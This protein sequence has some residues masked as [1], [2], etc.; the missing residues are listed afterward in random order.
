MGQIPSSHFVRSISFSE[1]GKQLA[2]LQVDGMLRLYKIIENNPVPQLVQ[3]LPGI[4]GDLNGKFQ[5]SWK[6]DDCL[7]V[8]YG[9]KSLR[10]YQ[11]SSGKW[12]IKS[13]FTPVSDILSLELISK[14]LSLI[15]CANDTISLFS[16][17]RNKILTSTQLS[18]LDKSS[19]SAANESFAC[20]FEP[21]RSDLFGIKIKFD[22]K[23]LIVPVDLKEKRKSKLS[24]LTAK[25]IKSK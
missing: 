3:T 18:N 11:M 5:V 16:T 6:G 14:E 23:D 2:F 7:G 25:R 22:S 8:L 13:E 24:K 15:S 9:C 12:E 4:K 21:S 17:T 10:I 20:I 19:L 1:D